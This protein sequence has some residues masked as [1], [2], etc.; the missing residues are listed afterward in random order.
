MLH[1]IPVYTTTNL[2]DMFGVFGNISLNQVVLNFEQ[3]KLKSV[4]II[5]NLS[6]ITH[7]NLFYYFLPVEFIITLQIK[8][9]FCNF[10]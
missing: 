2:N 8:S 4:K 1:F 6:H 9:L 3:N 5:P 10:A 7:G